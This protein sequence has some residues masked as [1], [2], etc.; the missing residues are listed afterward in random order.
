MLRVHFL[1]RWF[2][3]LNPAAE[4]GPGDAHDLRVPP[5]LLHGEE[6]RVLGTRPMRA[7]K[8]LLRDSVPGTSVD[9][10]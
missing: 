9:A 10:P 3:L 2:N 1:Q 7:G 4:E 8:A 6:M 5:D